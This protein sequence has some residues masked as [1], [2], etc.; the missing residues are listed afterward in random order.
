MKGVQGHRLIYLDSL[1]GICCIGVFIVH[2]NG[3]L[4]LIPNIPFFEFLQLTPIGILLNSIG[5][6]YFFVLS[7]FLTSR[8]SMSTYN[9]GWRDIVRIMVKRYLKLVPIVFLSDILIL[10]FVVKADGYRYSMQIAEITNNKWILDIT[11]PHG[12]IF[13]VCFDAFIRCFWIKSGSSY[14]CALWTVGYEFWG[15]GVLVLILQK[16]F[17]KNKYKHIIFWLVALIFLIV[18][19][20]EYYFAPIIGLIVANLIYSR[21]VRT[22][23][24]SRLWWC[25]GCG[26]VWIV[27]IMGQLSLS[28]LLEWKQYVLAIAF[29]MIIFGMFYDEKIKEILSHKIL[30]TLGM[31]SYGIYFFHIPVILT[32][33]SKVIIFDNILLTYQSKVCLSFAITCLIL[34]LIAKMVKWFLEYYNSLLS[35]I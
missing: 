14:N 17:Y 1:R 5:V 27:L 4:S 15:G 10:F 28:R 32:I 31:Y 20:E 13:R 26:I 7:G 35:N 9:L 21:P 6:G 12:S 25:V 33:S 3:A 16:V 22:I 29:G 18:I 34:V 19:K 11:P 2:F 30:Q 23:K 24:H 8:Q